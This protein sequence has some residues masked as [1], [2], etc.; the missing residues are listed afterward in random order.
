ML[1][2]GDLAPDVTLYSGDGSLLRT[3]DLWRDTPVV[4]NFLRHFG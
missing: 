1:T 2:A 4:L 3:P